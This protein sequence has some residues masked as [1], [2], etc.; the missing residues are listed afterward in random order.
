MKTS[1]YIILLLQ[2]TCFS[3]IANA[4]SPTQQAA[5]NIWLQQQKNLNPR[6]INIIAALKNKAKLYNITISRYN[7]NSNKITINARSKNKSNILQ[8]KRILD[9]TFMFEKILI[10]NTK[11]QNK[12]NYFKLNITKA[13]L[14]N[15]G[16]FKKSSHQIYKSNTQ[17]KYSIINLIDKITS[18]GQLQSL[19]PSKPLILKPNYV[20]ARIKL[21]IFSYHLKFSGSFNKTMEVLSLIS[22]NKKYISIHNLILKNNGAKY[23]LEA[24]LRFYQ[25]AS[26]SNN[27]DKTFAFEK[28]KSKKICAK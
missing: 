4:L 23:E 1:I 2:I 3:Q 18:M 12:N 25:E 27:R 19:C 8:Y 26:R 22:N 13:N 14:D 6:P 5:I 21:I 9:T 28:V 16:E 15:K 11:S 10:T 17:V 24:D 7:L 20:G